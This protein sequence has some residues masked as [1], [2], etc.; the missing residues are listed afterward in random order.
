M[1]NILGLYFKE[2]QVGVSLYDVPHH[3]VFS[4]LSLRKSNDPTQA[5]SSSV[6]SFEHLVVGLFLWSGVAAF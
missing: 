5:T 1:L 3:Q 2:V 4:L 6:G